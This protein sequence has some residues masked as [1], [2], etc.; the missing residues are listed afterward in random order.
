MLFEISSMSLLLLLAFDLNRSREKKKIILC[1]GTLIGEYKDIGM[2]ANQDVSISNNVSF[3]KSI[4]RLA[5]ENKD[6]H[7]IIK[8]KTKSLFKIE[9]NKELITS[10]INQ[11]NI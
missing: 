1:L 5:S 8:Y 6:C 4:N 7:F 9:Q 10:C 2:T 3:L 11:K